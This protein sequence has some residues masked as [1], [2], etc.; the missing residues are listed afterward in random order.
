MMTA[1]ISRYALLFAASSTL[2]FAAHAQTAD[3][4]AP[5]IA[6]ADE[7]DDEVIVVT[8]SRIGIDAPIE[9]VSPITVVDAETIETLG[10]A[11]LATLLRDIPA[12]QGT[13]PGIDSVNQAAQGDS[14]DL[15][16]SLLNLRQLGTV[17]TLTLVDGRRHV[18]GTG[19]SAAV[20]INAIPTPRIKSVEVLTGGASAVYGAD[21]VTGVVNFQLRSGRDFDGLEYNVRTGISDEG[22][23]ESYYASLAAGGTFADGR[24]SAVF[25]A[26]YRRQ[27]PLRGGDRDFAGLGVASFGPTNQAVLDA[28]GISAADLGLPDGDLPDN[29]F[30]PNQ[31]LPISSAS[32]IIAVGVGPSGFVAGATAANLGATPNIGGTDIPLAQIVEN[33]VLRRFDPGIAVDPFTA[34][35]GDGITQNPPDGII[36]PELDQVVVSAAADYEI[37]SNVEVFVDGK[38][39]FTEGLDQAGIPFSDDI[40]IQLDNPFVPTELLAQVNQLQE[41][42]DNDDD[43]NN[44]GTVGIAVSRD[45]LDFDIDPLENTD[46]TTWRLVGGLR[47]EIPNLGWDW[48]VSYNYGR[49]EV[50]TVFRN[51]RI[52]DRYYYAIDA[53]ALNE[54]NIDTFIANNATATAIRGGEGIEITPGSAQI[55]DIIC[56]SSLDGSAPA[57]SPFPAPPTNDDGLGQ[58][59]TFLPGDGQ[60]APINILGDGAIMGPGADFAFVDIN[61]STVL[62]QQQLLATIAGDTESFFLLPGGAVGFAAGF[63]YRRDTSQFT[64]SPFQ[65]APP[66]TQA[67]NNAGPIFPS[68]DPDFQD[69]A[70]EVYEGFAE[71]R[72]PLLADRRFVDLLEVTGAIRFSDYN[73]IG[74]TTAWTVGGRYKPIPAL[75]LRG[76]YSVAVRA[77][78]LAE[79]FGPV[80]PA[81]IGLTADPC[82]DA[83]IDAGSAFREA[84]CRQFVGDSFNPADFASAFRSG[85]TGGNPN[86]SEEEAETFTVG[87]VFQPR[88]LLPGLTLIAD[89]YD[90][91]IEGAIDSLTGVEIASACVDLPTT[92][93]QF[94][95]QIVRDSETGLIDDFTSGNINLGS[96]TAR[97]IDFAATYEFPVPG[98]NLGD[99]QLSA[100]GT[101][102]LEEETVFDATA[103]I[104]IAEIA[105]PLEQER[106]RIANDITNDGLGELGSP[107][108]IVNFGITW[109]YDRLTLGYNGRFESSQLSPG[110]DNIEVVDVAIDGDEVVVRDDN[111]F[112]ALPQRDTGSSIISD[113]VFSYDIADE[114]NVY[115]GI[116]NAFDIEPYLGSLVRPIG[117]R[118]RFFYLGLRG[119]F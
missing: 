88:D 86:L 93:N 87:F 61:N 7:G 15:G 104:L 73:T 84:N 95:E 99:L 44:D 3:A 30:F 56:R 58:A 115:G 52:E 118:G 54:D 81:L 110:I 16:L 13:L 48:E 21:A 91:R 8:G 109:N 41:L 65:N 106:A 66:I 76:T 90:I 113:I 36:L 107:E 39:A 57:V 47:G 25:S 83:N 19:G 64:P 46:R 50:Q 28:I 34:L 102:F 27:T 117:V 72:A 112:V 68:P 35:G 22:D 70:I 20:D 78:N 10:E 63:E 11:D 62:T 51:V 55:G 45:N 100:T 80:T 38:F 4:P 6:V 101:H 43:E 31:R 17:R 49:T 12:L 29:A 59:L 9:S 37:T 96:L 98:D 5:A 92:D 105:D 32:G 40:P 82:A 97:G 119:E 14:S 53:V 116:N 69:P 79:L 2:P 18:P 33:G 94:C 85:T 114:L 60:C 77:P 24:G 75:T 1:N 108:W 103:D 42:V 71:V 26:E 89:Y 23:A 111:T 67:T 74:Q